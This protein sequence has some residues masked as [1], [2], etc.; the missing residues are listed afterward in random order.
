[1]GDYY[2]NKFNQLRELGYSQ[3]DAISDIYNIFLDGKLKD[4]QNRDKEFWNSQLFNDFLEDMITEELFL[5]AFIKKLQYGTIIDITLIE[6]VISIDSEI[7]ISAIKYSKIF[8][9]FEN[10]NFKN[11]EKVFLENN[12][13]C[14]F[15]QACKILKV[16]L[17]SLNSDIESC[18]EELMAYSYLD[19]LCHMSIYMMK[20]TKEN[21]DPIVF[22]NNGEILTL[23][24]RKRLSDKDRKKRAIDEQYIDDKW[25]THFLKIESYENSNFEKIFDK[26]KELY[27]FKENKLSTFCFDENF[28]YRVYNDILEINVI[29]IEKY[30]RW[31]LNGQK[32]SELIK[33]YREEALICAEEQLANYIFGSIEN[34]VINKFVYVNTLETVLLTQEQYGLADEIQIDNNSSIPLFEAI[35]SINGLKGLYQ[36]YFLEKYITYLNQSENWLDAWQK[37]VNESIRTQKNRLPLI[38][39]RIDEFS[40]KMKIEDNKKIDAKKI[41]NFWTMDLREINKEQRETPNIFEKPLMKIDDYVFIMPFFIGHQNSSTSFINSL[42][43]GSNTR[44]DR[45]IEVQ[46]SENYLAQ[47]FRKAGFNA[48]SNYDLPLSNVYDIGDVDVICEK[49]GY[50]FVLELKSTYIRTSFENIWKYK[51]QKLRKAANQLQKRQFLITKLLKDK[52]RDFIDEF[53]NPKKIFYWIVDT[54]FEFDHEYFSGYLKISL[55]EIMNALIIEEKNLSPHHFNIENFVEKIENGT[56]WS[57]LKLENIDSKSINYKIV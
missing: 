19:L 11:I 14:D 23:I 5:L 42:L 3:K 43:S 8:L 45:K 46:T 12:I 29:D 55:F 1:M 33:Y 27:L 38:Y 37:L 26:Y 51:T 41:E 9:D 47:Q 30:K 25:K 6:K 35:Y 48:K 22:Q 15:F 53:G 7:L 21:L 13:S 28:S 31:H 18:S 39:Q 17:D 24:L 44:Y 52:N 36:K 4:M 32:I 56:I 2:Y 50:L 57:H 34:D 40:K 16:K 49:D 10:T 20:H 54:T